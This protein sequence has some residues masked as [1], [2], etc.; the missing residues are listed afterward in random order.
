[1]GE[2]RTAHDFEENDD[3]VYAGTGLDDADRSGIQRSFA[4]TGA[5]GGLLSIAA[6]LVG[7]S[8]ES[9]GTENKN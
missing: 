2:V 5:T 4:K 9:H 7:S 3:V 6:S 8:V 1:M